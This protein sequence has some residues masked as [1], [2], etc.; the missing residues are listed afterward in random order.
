MILPPGAA[1]YARKRQE[2]EEKLKRLF[3]EPR[4]KNRGRPL[5]L[6]N[7]HAILSPGEC[8]LLVR[9]FQGEQS[10][11][12]RKA[13]CEE[14]GIPMNVLRIRAHRLRRRV[15]QHVA[16]LGDNA[17]TTSAEKPYPVSSAPVVTQPTHCQAPLMD[18]LRHLL[19]TLFPVLYAQVLE[20]TLADLR[21]EYSAVLSKGHR[22]KA[23]WILLQG[24][25]AIAAAA[26]YQLGFSLLGH[27]A[28]LW[29]ARNSK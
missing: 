19:Q 5:D 21:Q 13:L 12:S 2:L 29:Q 18:R 23:C 14:L 17:P 8:D 28:A 15:E 22:V 6:G 1:Q 7:A 4:E 20:P 3:K 16:Q 9:Y 25:G 27:F 24:C 26:V 10:F 11:R